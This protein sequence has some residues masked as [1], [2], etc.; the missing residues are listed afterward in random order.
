MTVQKII[1]WFYHPAS[2]EEENLKILKEFR[3]LVQ[4]ALEITAELNTGY[5]TPEEINRLM[6]ELTGKEIDKSLYMFPPFYSEF[7]KN[8]TIGK[9]VF[10]NTCCHFQDQ[11]GIT[12][13]DNCFIGPN[14]VLATVNHALDPAENRKNSYAPVN[15]KAHVWIGANAVILPGVTVGEW[16][17]IGAGAVVTKDVEPYTVVGG[18]P[19]R[20][21]KRVK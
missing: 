6:S 1:D 18:S 2:S 9:N 15:I 16:S 17:V 5:H 12:I 8:I 10:I 19:A 4:E 13:G 3:V 20:V 11:G 21:I 7:G 14:V